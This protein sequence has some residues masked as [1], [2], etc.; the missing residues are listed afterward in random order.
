MLVY[1][2]NIHSSIFYQTESILILIQMRNSSQLF[3]TC[4]K[5]KGITN[6]GEN[7]LTATCQKLRPKYDI[8]SLDDNEYF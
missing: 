4:C 8:Q 6:G 1:F 2:D 7:K 5:I 3:L